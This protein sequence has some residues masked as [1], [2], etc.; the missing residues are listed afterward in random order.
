MCLHIW[1]VT[2]TWVGLLAPGP[3]AGGSRVEDKPP[4]E[5]AGWSP[6]SCIFSMGS[7]ARCLFFL[8]L[9]GTAQPV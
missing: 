1:A 5:A 4:F 8:T 7:E 3:P 2:L 6:A 9:S